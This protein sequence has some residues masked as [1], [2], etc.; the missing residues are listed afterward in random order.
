MAT[1]YTG[2]LRR[3]QPE[4]PYSLGGWCYGGIVA[5]EMAQQLVA[6]SQR[7]AFLGL[8]ETVAPTPSLRIYRRHLHRMACLLQMGPAQWLRYLRKKAQYHREAKLANK[9]RFRRLE[10]TEA[11]SAVNLE[12][13]NQ[14]LAQLEHVYRTNLAALKHYSPRR[15]PGRVAGVGG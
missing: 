13:H 15:Y 7:I 2:L 6:M 11:T 5:V 1:Y 12:E 14:R 3:L 4:G 10:K 9:M 8:L